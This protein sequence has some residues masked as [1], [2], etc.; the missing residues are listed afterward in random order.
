M[1]LNYIY[2]YYYYFIY[3]L[4][5][6]TLYLLYIFTSVISWHHNVFILPSGRAGKDFLRELTR[7]MNELNNGGPTAPIAMKMLMIAGPI[8][9]QKPS[10]SSKTKDH[11]MYLTRRMQLWNEGRLQ[12]LLKECHTI[13]SR[14]TKA[15]HH[16]PDPM[17]IFTRL[18]LKGQRV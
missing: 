6:Y 12:E 11:T 18:M 16:K 7:I 5:I 8:L 14:L 2:Y 3:I 10:P 9:L 13:Q 15:R 1:L 17:K 4:Y